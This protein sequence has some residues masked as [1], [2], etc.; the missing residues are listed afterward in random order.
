MSKEKE[1]GVEEGKRRMAE[2]DVPVT[3]RK[4]H[5]PEYPVEFE[6]V[7]SPRPREWLKYTGSI[8]KV[9]RCTADSYLRNYSV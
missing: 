1:E 6:A 7:I 9:D 4:I 8:Y 3:K 2:G 5:G